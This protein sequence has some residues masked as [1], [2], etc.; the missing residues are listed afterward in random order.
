MEQMV[1]YLVCVVVKFKQIG[2]SA[3]EIN[4]VKFAVVSQVSSVQTGRESWH[5]S[6]CSRLQGP[7][8]SLPVGKGGRQESREGLFTRCCSER[9][10]GEEAR[11]R[12]KNVRYCEGGEA[13]ERI[14]QRAALPPRCEGSAA[15]PTGRSAAWF[16]G[17]QPGSVEGIP[18]RAR[19]LALGDLHGAFRHKSFCASL[20]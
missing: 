18:A 8:S 19:G 5:C 17:R 3:G 10:K 4:L 15:D 14:A 20:R 1:I 9:A 11:C 6:A 2:F 7:C 16:G 12:C 13:L